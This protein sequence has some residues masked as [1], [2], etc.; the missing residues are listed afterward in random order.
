MTTSQPGPRATAGAIAV[1]VVAGLAA[2]AAGILFLFSAWVSL[3]SRFGTASDQHGYGLL[4]GAFLAIMAGFVLAVVL[5]FVFPRRL[6]S[7]VLRYGM[8]G[9]AIVFVVMIALVLTA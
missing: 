6:W 3:S 2:S 1:R 8:L 9:F 4:F 7:R 5:P